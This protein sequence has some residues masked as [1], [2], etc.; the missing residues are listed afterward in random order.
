MRSLGFAAAISIFVMSLPAAAA[1]GDI[2][3]A[4][5]QAGVYRLVTGETS[6]KII[7]LPDGLT[8]LRRVEQQYQMRFNPNQISTEAVDAFAAEFCTHLGRTAAV[9]FAER[10][11][12][13][14]CR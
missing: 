11:A 8:D 13:I 12:V 9:G 10:V 3:R 2:D 1:V 14:E 6:G 4:A 7:R 5:G